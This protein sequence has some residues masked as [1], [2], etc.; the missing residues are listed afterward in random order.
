MTRV[1]NYLNE[2]QRVSETYSALFDT[3]L[4]ESGGVEVSQPATQCNSTVTARLVQ[5]TADQYGHNKLT[6]LWKP[7]RHMVKCTFHEMRSQT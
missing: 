2:M 7:H 1:A 5:P 4:R 3:I 6:I